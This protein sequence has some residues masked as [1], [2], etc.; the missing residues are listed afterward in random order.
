MFADLF[1]GALTLK[2]NTFLHHTTRSKA[3]KLRIAPVVEGHIV[4]PESSE[5]G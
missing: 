1:R 5:L 3:V 2:S 4:H